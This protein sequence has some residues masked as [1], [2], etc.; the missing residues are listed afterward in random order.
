MTYREILDQLILLMGQD[1]GGDFEDMAGREVNT[2]YAQLLEEA[3]TD[4]ERRTFT[5]SI[6][7]GTTEV[8]MPMSV[9]RVL[10]IEDTTNSRTLDLISRAEYDETWA[11]QAA[12]GQPLRAYP[13]KRLGVKA[14]PGT[15]GALTIESSSSSDSGGN[16][17]VAVRGLSSAVPTYET[18][19]LA[20]TTPQST[21]SSYDTENG[22]ERISLVPA[23]GSTFSGTITVKDVDGDTICEIAPYGERSTT[24][25]WWGFDPQPD[26]A[27]SYTVRAVVRRSPLINDGDWPELEEKFHGLLVHGPAIV[28]APALGQGEVAGASARMF[29]KL[30]KT[31]EG[32]HQ[33]RSRRRQEFTAITGPG[34]AVPRGRPLIA[35][36]DYR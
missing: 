18:V 8:G 3:E 24:Y 21:A 23:S 15:A 16:F 29:D 19:Q 22:V 34:A 32:A 31:F 20:G 6:G 35:G 7:S 36:I 11:T 25:D 1:A 27:Y 10:N 4:L 33:R 30:Y 12:T 28:L 9:E 5:V 14:Q 26:A 2:I 17:L 13:A